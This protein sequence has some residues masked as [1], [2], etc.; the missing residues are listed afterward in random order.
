MPKNS[1]ENV[2]QIANR[3]RDVSSSQMLHSNGKNPIS[4]DTPLSL[5]FGWGIR[6]DRFKL[7]FG[8]APGCYIPLQAL[9][10]ALGKGGRRKEKGGAFFW[11]MKSDRVMEN[12]PCYTRWGGRGKEEGEGALLA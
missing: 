7:L 11:M 5:L 6:L 2:G 3:I 8:S 4:S 1:S 10:K 9:H 12:C